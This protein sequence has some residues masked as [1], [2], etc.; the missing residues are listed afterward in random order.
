MNRGE[1]KNYRNKII[2][3]KT[4]TVMCYEMVPNQQIAVLAKVLKVRLHGVQYD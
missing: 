3:N 2:Q 1:N 4:K